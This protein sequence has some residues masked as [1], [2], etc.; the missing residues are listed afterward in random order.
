MIMAER[1]KAILPLAREKPSSISPVASLACSEE[2]ASRISAYFNTLLRS[3]K[4]RTLTIPINARSYVRH[5]HD[6]LESI[7]WAYTRIVE[8][9]KSHMLH[10]DSWQL[11]VF[12]DAFREHLVRIC[13]ALA[14]WAD[15]RRNCYEP[16]H[17]TNQSHRLAALQLQIDSLEQ[18]WLTWSLC[19][20]IHKQATSCSL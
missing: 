17:P 18:V 5:N 20:E 4:R 10:D 7:A 12:Q 15:A 2:V 14:E 19:V 8:L 9:W 6:C 11:N 16:F 3:S 13:V 1:G